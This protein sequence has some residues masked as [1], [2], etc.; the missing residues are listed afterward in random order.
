MIWK[1]TGIFFGFIFFVG[2]AAAQDNRF[3]EFTSL[4]KNIDVSQVALHDEVWKTVAAYRQPLQRQ[5]L[6]EPKPAEVGVKQ[7]HVQSIHDDKF[8]S[9]RLVWADPTR[10]ETP[11]IMGFSDGAA[12]QFP[13]NRENLPAFFMGEVKKPV[14]ILYWKAWRSKD[15]KSGFQTTKSAYPNMTTDIYTFDYPVKGTGTEKTQSEKNIFIPGRAADNPISFPSKEVIT[16]LSATGPGTITF[17]KTA[18][19]SG[20]AEWENGQWTVIFRRPLTVN[21]PGS[22][23]FDA[24]SRM[25]VAFAV[26]EGGRMES[27]GRKAVSPAWAEVEIQK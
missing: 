10:D 11:S 4:K 27:G 20:A 5:F 19:T 15:K 8:I 6:V 21:E 3:V 17:L 1:I 13:V 24:G 25:P 18:D 2:G 23:R 26:W 22:V 16:E 14:H 7:V 9:F 12:V